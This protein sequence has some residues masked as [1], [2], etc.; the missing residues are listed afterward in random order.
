MSA[1]LRVKVRGLLR[2]VRQRVIDLIVDHADDLAAVFKRDPRAFA[3]GH[4]PEA[5]HAAI[6]V[7]GDHGGIQLHEVGVEDARV[8]RRPHGGEKIAQRTFDARLRLTVPVH[9]DD[10]VAAHIAGHPHALNRAAALD[11]RHFER[12]AGLN[13]VG[14]RNL[15]AA[16]E[17]ARALRAGA[18]GRQCARVRLAAGVLGA[19]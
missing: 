8:V 5:V 19:D 12:L 6:R 7:H 3:E 2:H 16:A 14:R 11:E 18:L 9:A 15:P 10:H 4:R 17:A 1:K 13:G